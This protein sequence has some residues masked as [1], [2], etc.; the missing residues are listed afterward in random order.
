MIGL[1]FYFLKELLLDSWIN[2]F[3]Y[4][5]TELRKY[6]KIYLICG[7]HKLKKCFGTEIFMDEMIY[8]L[9]FFQTCPEKE[10]G[11][12]IHREN[13]IGYGLINVECG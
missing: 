1:N 10:V 8:C 4:I 2:I 12:Y 9:D 5:S 6:L 3:H 13:K 11:G 7:Q